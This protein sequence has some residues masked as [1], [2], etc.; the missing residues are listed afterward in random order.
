[1]ESFEDKKIT[2]Y[3]I[4]ANVT[5][6]FEF[7]P[8]F[9][10]YEF[11]IV[12]TACIIGFIFFFLLGLPKKTVSTAV[13]TTVTIQ[14]QS[15]PQTSLEI[16]DK[17][18]SYVPIIIRILFIIIPGISAFFVVKRDPSSGMSFITIIKSRQE[19]VKKQRRYLDV[20]GS[21]TEV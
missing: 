1:M 21:G 9:G 5:T 15:L 13:P 11:K 7:F 8:G 4:P 12:I 10:W 18:V 2:Q 14:N 17:K 19:F 6:R 20:Y 16:Q 3:L